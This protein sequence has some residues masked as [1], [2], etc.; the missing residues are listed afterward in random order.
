[1]LSG[2]TDSLNDKSRNGGEAVTGLFVFFVERLIERSLQANP[3]RLCLVVLVFFGVERH[4]DRSLHAHTRLGEAP[5]ERGWG[6]GNSPSSVEPMIGV[7][8]S[9]C[10]VVRKS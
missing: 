3:L 5:L 6:P 10:E 9:L 8:F 4:H 2:P 7:L 1:M